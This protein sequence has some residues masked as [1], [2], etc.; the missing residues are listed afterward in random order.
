MISR[1]DRNRQDLID[2]QRSL[3]NGYGSYGLHTDKNGPEKPAKED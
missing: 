3:Y 2:D 1:L